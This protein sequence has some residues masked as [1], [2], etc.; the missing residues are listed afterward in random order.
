M[1]WWTVSGL[2]VVFSRWTSAIP[3]LMGCGTVHA[4]GQI[5]LPLRDL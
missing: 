5:K 1:G 4:R 3:L 2:G